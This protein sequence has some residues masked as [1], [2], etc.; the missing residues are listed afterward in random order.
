MQGDPPAKAITPTG[1][2]FLSY[3]SE[4]AAAAERIAA[5][6]CA[7]GIEVWFDKS[8]LR[9]GDAWDRQIRK[10]IHDCALFVAIISAHSDARHEGYF[11]REWRLAVERAGDIAEDVPFLLPVVIDGTK[12]VAA[13]VPDRF[14]EVQW[15]HLPERTPS[16]T[17]VEHVRR[18]LSPEAAPSA[19]SGAVPRSLPTPRH[20]ARVWSRAWVVVATV[21]AAVAVGYFAFERLAPERAPPSAPVNAASTVAASFN[22]PPHSIAVL[23]FVNMSGDKAQE[24][25]SDGLTEELL[26]A[27]A[28]TNELEVSARTSSFSFKDTKADIST[29][30]RKLNVGAILEGSVRR[31]GHTLRVTAQLNNAVTGFHLWSQTYDR[32]LGDVLKL[33]TEI[34][35]AVATALRV[36]LL[37]DVAAKIELGGTHNAAAFDAY[38]RGIEAYSRWQTKDL[39]KAI[40]AYTEATHLDPN[41]A[42]AYAGRS[43]AHSDFASFQVTSTA[44]FSQELAKARADAQRALAL[45]PELAEGHLA[46]AYC[47]QNSLD[48]H[49]AQSEFDQAR[50]RAPSNAEILRMSGVF[51]VYM[52]HVDSGLASLR[53][54]VVLDRLNPRAYFWLGEGLGMAH[55]YEEALAAYDQTIALKQDFWEAYGFRGNYLYLRGDLDRA[56]SSCTVRSGDWAS[57]WCLALVYEKL[58]RRTDAEAAARGMAAPVGDTVAYQYVT[59]FAQW[60]DASKALEWLDTALR[61]RDPGLAG[62]KSDPLLDP[63]RNEPRFQ[64]IERALKFPQ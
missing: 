25:F 13:R 48:F 43:L 56:Q 45:A 29:I 54:A 30:A 32:D 59:I 63:L 34:A 18:L 6:L 8:E 38:L 51:A 21:V 19:L 58:G 7:A 12:D 20:R 53:R 57:Q 27:L 33:Q 55:R 11:R 64:A 62:L 23:P 15:S 41:Y 28:R 22:P 44:A 35:T 42:L 61:V 2:V 60:G 40:A 52:G 5:A 10:Q 26:N 9:G 36:T 3:A 14:R 47:S 31:S 46:S 16:A 50:A 49:T 4:D 1:A 24:Y 17:F 37:G 39:Q